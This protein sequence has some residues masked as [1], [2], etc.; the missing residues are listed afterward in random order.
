MPTT[1]M[2]ALRDY[3]IALVKAI[4][5]AKLA[6]TDD[7]DFV[8]YRNEGAGDFIDWAE[9]NPQAAFRRFQ[10]RDTGESSVVPDVN[11][12]DIVGKWV[13]FEVIVSYPQTL[14]AGDDA[15]LARDALMTDDERLIDNVIG[16]QGY[17]NFVGGSVPNASLTEQ[18]ARRVVGKGVDFLVVTLTYHFYRTR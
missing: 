10:I 18:R 16:L 4:Q 6:E 3:M 13:D 11:N 1:T 2:T 7:V 15:A 9:D 12:T 8:P 17:P 5:P 14:R